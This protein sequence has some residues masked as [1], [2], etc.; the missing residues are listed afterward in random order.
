MDF[1]DGYDSDSDNQLTE[2]KTEKDSTLKLE[3]ISVNQMLTEKVTKVKKIEINFLPPEI[4]MALARGDSLNDSDDEDIYQRVSSKFSS[5][6]NSGMKDLLSLL[7]KPQNDEDYKR[8]K[9]DHRVKKSEKNVS[10]SLQET[11]LGKCSLSKSELGTCSSKEL[12]NFEMSSIYPPNTLQSYDI[13]SKTDIVPNLN[14][15]ILET[16]ENLANFDQK[17]INKRR[18]NAR[19]T[20]YSLLNGNIDVLKDG[21]FKEIDSSV[22]NKWD[23]VTYLA[24]Q[25]LET[26]LQASLVDSNIPTRTQN[27]KHQIN[28]LAVQAAKMELSL[29]EA[30]GT[31]NRSKYETQAKYGW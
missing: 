20:E 15:P 16:N 26:E 5:K 25:E 18:R 28:S 1:L 29:L 17:N 13:D 4:Q 14:T 24:Q 3:D 31:K 2:K 11:Q 27:R 12:F 8:T 22:I 23:V 10:N 19:D 9:T 21:K 6:I 7:P 30:K